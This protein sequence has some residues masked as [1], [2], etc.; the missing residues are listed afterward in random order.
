MEKLNVTRKLKA[1]LQ[2]MEKRKVREDTVFASGGRGE[3]FPIA[4]RNLLKDLPK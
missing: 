3:G 2:K 4:I 1:H